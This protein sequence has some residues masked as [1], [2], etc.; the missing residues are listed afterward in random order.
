MPPSSGSNML[1]ESLEALPEQIRASVI[2]REKELIPVQL[3]DTPT[4]PEGTTGLPVISRSTI[5][6][7]SVMNTSLHLTPSSPLNIIR[8]SRAPSESPG[9]PRSDFSKNSEESVIIIGDTFSAPA[10]LQFSID[11]SPHVRDAGAL[12]RYSQSVNQAQSNSSWRRENTS[13][14]LT[15]TPPASFRRPLPSPPPRPTLSSPFTPHSSTPHT[16]SSGSLSISPISRPRASPNGPRPLGRLSEPADT[17]AKSSRWKKKKKK[18][19][20]LRSGG[21]GE[22]MSPPRF[23]TSMATSIQ[24]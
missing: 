14:S 16:S 12:D 6:D 2:R 23:G 22:T 3:P 17:G 8:Q 13:P 7:T 10:N 24:D 1:F 9:S 4:P 20:Y 15:S 11:H 21:D 5:V 18:E 19:E